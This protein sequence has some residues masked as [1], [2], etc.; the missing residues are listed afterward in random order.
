MLTFSTLPLA[1]FWSRS[2]HCKTPNHSEIQDEQSVWQSLNR[3]PDVN[4]IYRCWWAEFAFL[5]IGAL[6]DYWAPPSLCTKILWATPRL[7]MGGTHCC[8][9][10]APLSHTKFPLLN[11]LHMAIS[12]SLRAQSQTFYPDPP[13]LNTRSWSPTFSASPAATGDHVIHL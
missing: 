2:E 10:G 13:L 9:L 4:T 1:S 7:A 5:H 8:F 12:S 11:A 6:C 3:A